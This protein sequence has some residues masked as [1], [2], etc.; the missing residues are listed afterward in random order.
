VW[1][2]LW[3]GF[4][5]FIHLLEAA[6]LGICEI[7]VMETISFLLLGRMNAMLNVADMDRTI[8]SSWSSSCGRQSVDQFVW[9][10]GLPLGPLTRF[11]LALPFFGSQLLEYS[12]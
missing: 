12:F 7:L 3:N 2:D 10:S 9:V 6:S 4:D 8:S 5:F 1:Q 11:N